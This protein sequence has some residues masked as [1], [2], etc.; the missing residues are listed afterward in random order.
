MRSTLR[1]GMTLTVIL[2]L[3]LAFNLVWVA[4]IPDIRWDF[5]EKK[6][7]PYPLRSTRYWYP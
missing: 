3:F 7:I 6:S 1:T 4:K 2:L 5:S